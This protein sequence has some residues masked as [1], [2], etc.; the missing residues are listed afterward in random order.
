MRP[1]LEGHD[2]Q[3]VT[4]THASAEA[5]RSQVQR[6]RLRFPILIDSDLEVT[7]QLGWFDRAG[8]KHVTWKV[9][10]IPIGFPVG[11]REMPRPATVLID[12]AG[13]VRWLDV[14]DDYR[15]RGDEDRIR[16]AVERAF[17]RPGPVAPE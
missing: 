9:L 6:D 8:L 11:I 13:V 15:L 16:A 10:G 2:V 4:M 12:E 3:I 7:R 1:W 14:T 17:S 5:V